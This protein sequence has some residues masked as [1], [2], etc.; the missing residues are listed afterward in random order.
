MT[1]SKSLETL[2]PICLFCLISVASAEDGGGAKKEELKKT[3]G[4]SD[5]VAESITSS[6]EMMFPV[7]TTPRFS[8]REL[9]IRGNNLVS[10]AELVEKLPVAYIVHTGE[11]GKSA[12]EIYDF[13]AL[14][15]LVKDPGVERSVSLKTI[16]GLT[17]YILSRYQEEGYAGI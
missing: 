10:T 6:D 12:E 15:D 17:K 1:L 9:Q 5:N 8:V 7:D 16:Q 14:C 3:L 4:K 13:R 11:D 2:A